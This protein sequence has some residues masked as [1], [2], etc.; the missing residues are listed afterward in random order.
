MFLVVLSGRPGESTRAD[1]GFK[2]D[3]VIPTTC[4]NELS[5]GRLLGICRGRLNR[6]VR[7][8]YAGSPDGDV[9][10]WREGAII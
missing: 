7:V 9:S 3:T 1:R 4:E 5:A 8:R 6:L 10:P 2:T